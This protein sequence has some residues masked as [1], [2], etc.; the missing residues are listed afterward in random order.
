MEI[1]YRTESYSGAGE[2]SAREVIAFEA[3]E[4]N[5]ADIL[6]TLLESGLI[7]DTPSD[8]PNAKN[9]PWWDKSIADKARCMIKEIDEEGFVDD[10]D[11]DDF[12]AVA[13]EILA[14]VKEKTGKDIKF[15]LWLCDKE[16]IATHYGKDMCDEYDY[17]AY[18]VGPVILSDLGTDGKLFGYEVMP[19]ALN[20][21][22][23]SIKFVGGFQARKT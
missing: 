5:N 3:G 1:M 2:R 9:T 16:A 23:E 11:E 14:S 4:L 21:E 19:E 18:E 22:L 13:D 17:S 15:A 6:E 7:T 20:I 8:N 10:M 12:L